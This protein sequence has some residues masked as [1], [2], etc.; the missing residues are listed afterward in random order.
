MG[1][2][3]RTALLVLREKDYLSS[4]EE[5]ARVTRLWIVFVLGWALVPAVSAGFL[6]S[7]GLPIARLAPTLLG[8]SALLGLYLRLTLREAV[9]AGDLDPE[10]PPRVQVRRRLA[11]LAA[12]ALLVVGVS[13][14]EPETETW[15]MAQNVVVASGLSVP[16]GLAVWLIGG[17]TVLTLLGTWLVT[18]KPV[19]VALI[20]LA[21]GA[22]AVAVRQLTISVAQLR[23]AREELA[24]SAVDQERLRFARDL[25]DLLGHSLSVVVLKSELAGRLLPAS[26]D[27]AVTE[28]R[29]VERLAR[30]ALQQVRTA[31]AGYRQP[32]LARELDAAREMLAAAGI[33]ESIA[34]SAGALPPALDG[35]L[36]WAVREGVTNVIRHSRAGRCEIRVRRS[37]DRAELT[38]ID[39]GQAGRGGT[40]SSGSGLA[41]LAER[42]SSLGARMSAGP[43][44]DGR[45]VLVISAPAA[46]APAEAAG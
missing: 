44:P 31:V 14:S 32:V 12:M 28:M 39:D 33:S 7:T 19:V 36:A 46:G 41:G 23:A 6:V 1:E 35:L 21:F 16:A 18:G 24:R 26:P 17:V 40:P 45:F 42:A 2:S 34:N 8:V 9:G 43:L 27:R 30:E 15:W 25:H 10:G 20:L 4:I 13:A 3:R 22:S 5:G 37:G 38:V 11:L 29:D